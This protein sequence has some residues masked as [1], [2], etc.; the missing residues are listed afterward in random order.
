MSYLRHLCLFAYNYVQ[1]ILCCVFCF[2]CLR[3][4]SCVHNIAISLDCTFLIASSDS[5]TFI[6]IQNTF[7]A[8]PRKFQHGT[9]TVFYFNHHTDLTQQVSIA[10][11]NILDNNIIS[12]KITLLLSRYSRACGS[13]QDF[14][15][16]GFL[17]K[18]NLLNQWFILPKLKSSL[19]KFCGH[20]FLVGP[21]GIFKLFLSQKEYTRSYFNI[22]NS[23]IANI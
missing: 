12:V 13:Y 17:L 15:D 10:L 9:G 16:R 8:F 4:V 18:M 5:L 20:R 3:L 21:F 11:S 23:T 22:D 1:Y 7:Y 14:L 2:V 6:N 19:R